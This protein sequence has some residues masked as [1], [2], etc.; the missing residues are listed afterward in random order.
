MR[1]QTTPRALQCRAG[2][3]VA[4]IGRRVVR[5]RRHDGRV[6]RVDASRLAARLEHKARAMRC[7]AMTR[8]LRPILPT[9]R[10]VPVR[11]APRSV[12]SPGARDR[13]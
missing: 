1:D 9:L 6:E 5:L 2:S 11:S 13:D 3:D 7:R 12:T 10:R 4:G 8:C